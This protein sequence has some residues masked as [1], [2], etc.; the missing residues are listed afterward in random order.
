MN[1]TI[2]KLLHLEDDRFDIKA[3]A[4]HPISLKLNKIKPDIIY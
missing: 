2:A 3:L 1:K 4:D